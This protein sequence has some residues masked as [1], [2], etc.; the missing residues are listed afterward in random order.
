LRK[1]ALREYYNELS[2]TEDEF[3][4]YVLRSSPSSLNGTAFI[5]ENNNDMTDSYVMV[6][7][8]GRFISNTDGSYRTSQPILQVGIASALSDVSYDRAQF[9]ARGG[10]YDW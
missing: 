8:L 5:V 2:V 3:R 1:S 4:A 9:E 7:P 10:L 6:D